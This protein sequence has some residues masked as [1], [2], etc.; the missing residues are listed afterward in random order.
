MNELF[1]VTWV[2]CSWA[3]NHF[4][5]V[6]KS[7]MFNDYKTAV[8]FSTSAKSTDREHLCGIPKVSKL[9]ELND[10][11]GAVILRCP[12]VRDRY[13]R[14]CGLDLGHTEQHRLHKNEDHGGFDCTIVW[15]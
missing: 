7:K 12:S 3:I 4:D 8:E 1:I 13:G 11:Q 5:C 2:A 6:D 9:V 10:T 14:R 15:E